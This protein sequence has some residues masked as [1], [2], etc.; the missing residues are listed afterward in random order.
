[1]D[2]AFKDRVVPLAVGKRFVVSLRF[3][4]LGNV[5]ESNLSDSFGAT[6]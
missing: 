1:M 2:Q 4:R 5:P 6:S 3:K